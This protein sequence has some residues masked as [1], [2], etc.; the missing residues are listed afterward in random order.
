[1]KQ[2]LEVESDTYDWTQATIVIKYQKLT[3]CEQCEL[4]RPCRHCVHAQTECTNSSTPATIKNSKKARVQR[5]S[6]AQ[7]SILAL[8][9]EETPI[10]SRPQT[11]DESAPFGIG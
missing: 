3:I 5:Q 6:V 4:D 8:N 7:T 1:M 2:T 9:N 10:P 11:V